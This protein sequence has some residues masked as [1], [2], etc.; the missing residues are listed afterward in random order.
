TG[1]FAT[2]AEAVAAYRRIT[3][4]RSDME[5]Q[6]ESAKTKTGVFTG[7]FATNPVNGEQLPI[8]V[9]DYVLMGYG[10]G[11]IMAVPGQDVRDWE[12]AE[13]FELP[14]IRTVEPPEGFAGKAFTGEGPAI[15]SSIEG[16]TL[17]GLEITEAKRVII[18][19]LEEHGSGRGTTTYRLRDWLFS[20][21]RYWGEPFPI[22]YDE[23]GLPIAV[24]ESML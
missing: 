14:I 24:P 1:G 21:Q 10:T 19:W 3:A 12:F 16:L 23:T 13:V 20:R 22:L 5:R 18:S 6:A 11:A 7:V 15:N 8:F 2:P 4:T 17:D 9:A